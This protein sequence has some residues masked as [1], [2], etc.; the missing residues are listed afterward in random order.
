MSCETDSKQL[1]LREKKKKKNDPGH[2]A[3][4][5]HISL[6][7]PHTERISALIIETDFLWFIASLCDLPPVSCQARIYYTITKRIL[8]KKKQQ[9]TNSN[10]SICKRCLRYSHLINW[11]TSI[12]E[13][14]SMWAN[15]GRSPQ[16]LSHWSLTLMGACCQF[17]ASLISE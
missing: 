12:K 8:P 2:T 7:T 10:T 1:N 3:G 6:I 16:H 17:P 4:N 9:Q 5:Y 14:I 11:V 15:Q 13:G